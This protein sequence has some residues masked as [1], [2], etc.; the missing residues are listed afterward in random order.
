MTLDEISAVPMALLSQDF[1]TRAYIDSYFDQHQLKPH[2]AIEANSISTI[3]D[4][5]KS[6]ELVS[7]LPQAIIENSVKCTPSVWC[8]RYPNARQ[9]CCCI[10][11]TILARQAMPLSHL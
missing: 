7:V 11:R 5:V 2:L 8:P 3:L 1:A 9:P 6:S 4:L 10:K